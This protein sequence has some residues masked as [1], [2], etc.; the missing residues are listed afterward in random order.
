MFW[1]SS[2][3]KKGQKLAPPKAGD[4]VDVI[5][6]HRSLGDILPALWLF[7]FNAGLVQ[8]RSGVG[9]CIR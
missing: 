8:R 4:F 3:L 2:R 7:L 6:I 5:L 1:G 9:I